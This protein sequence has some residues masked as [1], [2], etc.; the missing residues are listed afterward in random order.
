MSHSRLP[1]LALILSIIIDTHLKAQSIDSTT[2]IDITYSP[3][4]DVQE[5]TLNPKRDTTVIPKTFQLSKRDIQKIVKAIRYSKE[6]YGIVKR[7]YSSLFELKGYHPS[8]GYTYQGFGSWDIGLGYGKRNLFK[9][10]TY[11]HIHTNVM[12]YNPDNKKTRLGLNLG[13]TKAKSAGYW[14]I[15]SVLVQN[16]LNQL[17]VALR[18][19]IGLS[20]LGIFNLGYGYTLP[21]TN[22]EH[23]F[24]A[25]NITIRYTHQFLKSSIE[26]KVREFNFIFQRDYRRLKEMGIDMMEK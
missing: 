17:N 21:L 1:F 12:L 5:D 14:G 23:N 11:T 15:E 3:I 26:K 25:H 8:I 4:E 18:P 10:L 13:Y 9:P 7:D 16:N 2:A 6:I 24:T 22:N 19:E 20:V